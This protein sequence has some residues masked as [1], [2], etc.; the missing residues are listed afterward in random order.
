MTRKEARYEASERR[1]AAIHEAGHVVAARLV[2]R[3]NIFGLPYARIWRET[4]DRLPEIGGTYTLWKGEATPFAGGLPLRD[5]RLVGVAG[6]VA[7]YVWEDRHGDYC[8]PDIDAI[9]DRLSDSDRE[10]SDA[11]HTISKRYAKPL[12]LSTSTGCEEIAWDNAMKRAYKLF[13]RDT[14]KLWP[15]LCQ[16]ARKLIVTSKIR[17]DGWR[18]GRAAA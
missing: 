10:L 5:Q 13:N 18:S 12:D 2:M 17:P 3:T 11:H 4:H 6:A 7:E 14:G 1:T 9:Y 16:E 8:V 15:A